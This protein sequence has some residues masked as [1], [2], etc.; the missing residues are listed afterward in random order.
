MKIT[1]SIGSRESIEINHSD[2]AH[3]ADWMDDDVRYSAFFSRLAA[4]PSS[5]VRCAMAGKYFLPAEM[6]EQ[7]ARDTSIEVVRRVANND[8][9]LRLLSLSVLMEMSERDVSVAADIADNL[10][11]FG[12]HE[13]E[14]LICE[15]SK[16]SDPKVVEAVENFVRDAQ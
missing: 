8:H 1:L 13:R 10:P 3:F 2:L 5:E 4:H 7:L 14:A 11:V 6:L 12:K 15:L 16:H 9:A